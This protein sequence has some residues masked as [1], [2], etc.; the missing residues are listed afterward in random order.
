MTEHSDES[1]DDVDARLIEKL[2]QLRGIEPPPE[3]RATFHRLVESELIANRRTQSVAWWRRSIRVPMPV[4][5][6]TGIAACALVF[7]KLP[8]AA[9]PIATAPKTL[10]AAVVMMPEPRIQKM[11]STYMLGVGQL[12]TETRSFFNQD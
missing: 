1:R 10:P 6:A 4:C 7:V 9:E 12:A 11:T 3:A 5:I 8:S 2:A